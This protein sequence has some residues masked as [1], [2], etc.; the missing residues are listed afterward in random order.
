MRRTFLI[1]LDE[2]CVYRL[3][4][5]PVLQ[6]VTT[7]HGSSEYVCKYDRLRVRSFRYLPQNAPE[8]FFNEDL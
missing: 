1:K 6:R 8:S 2:L 5:L 7:M 3:R 4:T